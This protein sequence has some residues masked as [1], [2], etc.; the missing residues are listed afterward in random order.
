MNP[1]RPPHGGKASPWQRYVDAA[2]RSDMPS[3][4]EPRTAPADRGPFTVAREVRIRLASALVPD[5]AG[6]RAADKPRHRTDLRLVPP[7]V[8]V[9]AAAVA[10]VWLP[11]AAIVAGFAFLV[12]GAVA[13]AG[14]LLRHRAREFSTRPRPRSALMTFHIALLLAAAAAAHSAVAATQRAEG[15]VADAVAQRLAVVV[16][17]E[18]TGAPRAL[19]APG[20]SGDDRWVVPATALVVI[21]NGTEIHTAAQLMIM[22]G[23]GWEEMVPGQRIRTAGKLKPPQDGQPEA[24][25]LSATTAPLTSEAPGAWQEGPAELRG[26]FAL[27]AAW[28]GG[29]ARGLLPGMVTGD[30]STLD[31]QLGSAMKTV[32]MTH[33]TA[34]SGANCSL[35]LGALLL[36]ARSLRLPRAPAAAFAL[37]GL[38]LFVLMV[39]PDASV[40]RAALMGGVGVASLSGG[41]AGRGLSF[42]CLAVI[43]LLLADPSLGTSFGFLLSVLA[44]LGIIVLGRSIVAW[45]PQVIPRWLAAGIAVPLSAQLLC[46]PVIVLLQPQ[47]SLYA[48]V[49]NVAAAPLVAPVTILGTAAVPLVPVLPWAAVPPIAVGGTC[50]GGVA[51]I[52]RFFAGLPGSALP[53]PDGPLGAATML[54]LSATTLASVWVAAHPRCTARLVRRCHGGITVW[55]DR[56]LPGLPR[57]TRGLEHRLGRDNLRGRNPISGRNQEWPLHRPHDRSPRRRTPPRGGT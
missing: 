52:A 14:V 28:L 46:G 37:G 4:A 45:L 44:T 41:R 18:I 39:G 17:A 31:E 27:A 25:L 35:I 2:V 42:L 7:A 57:R 15:A 50:A 19:K 34:V 36:T 51:A 33:L 12:A 13:L 32:G 43:G 11:P 10:G 40:L 5:P 23:A 16:E 47:F 8:L 24:G 1:A 3:S 22:G 56:L 6:T 48:L 54:M 53:W 21:S 20:R 26:R 29:D 55:L 30:T 49:A 38:A 9:W